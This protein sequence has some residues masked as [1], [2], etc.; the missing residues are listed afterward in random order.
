VPSKY[1]RVIYS[2]PPGW[3]ALGQ[4][5]GEKRDRGRGT[6]HH[7]RVAGQDLPAEGQPAVEGSSV[8]PF[9]TMFRSS[10]PG[11][12][13]IV[14]PYEIAVIHVGL[15]EKDEAFRSLEKGLPDRSVC[16][17]FLKVDPRLDR[18]RSDQRYIELV[19]R[20]AFN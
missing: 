7:G 14:S 10:L 19:R 17:P 8:R 13:R 5:R 4:R 16:V 2:P 18:I 3:A 1:L 15:G 6:G 20:L 11:L 9:T 12:N